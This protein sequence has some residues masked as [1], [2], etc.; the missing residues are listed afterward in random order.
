MVSPKA[1][2]S[3]R[4]TLRTFQPPQTCSKLRSRT[5]EARQGVCSQVVSKCG[6]DPFGLIC[7][8]RLGEPYI[9][10]IEDVTKECSRVC[11]AMPR[12]AID[13]SCM[14]LFIFHSPQS[15]YEGYFNHEELHPSL[16]F[17]KVY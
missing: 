7:W 17:M 10:A 3:E 11:R 4:A 8:V 1:V 5:R 15:S 13:A 2:D 14:R 12:N 16:C 9:C 6:L